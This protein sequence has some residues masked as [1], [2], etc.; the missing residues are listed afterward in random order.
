MDLTFTEEQQQFRGE[1]REWLAANKPRARFD[2]YYTPRGLEQHLTW[3]RTLFEAGYSAP[4][5]P[6]EVGGMGMDHWGQL[7]YDEECALAGLPERL[8]KMGLIHGGPTVLAHG[9]AEQQ[10]AWLPGIL[11][12]SDIWC[13]GF[14]EPDAGSD[15]AAVRTT[16]RVEGDRLIINGQ[17]TWTS[18]GAIASRMFALVRTDPSA[19]QHHGIS[20]VVF[21]LDL[22]G[23]EVRPMTQMHGHSGFAEVFF[24][25]VEVPLANV[26]GELNDGWRIA[27][28]SLRL[29]RGT[30][31][32]T[33]TRLVQSLRE[34]ADT[35]RERGADDS[36]VE[37][38]GSLRAWTFAYE[39]STYALTDLVSRGEDD[40]A[41]SSINKLAWS[42]IQTAVH[43]AHLDA[44][45]SD[46]EI[47]DEAGPNGEFVGM[48]R[49]YWHARAAEIFAGANEI[50][51]NIIAERGFGL[52]REPRG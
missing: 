7:I 22:P 30:G 37:N 21:D 25:D 51:R 19:S 26:V 3:E 47:V 28:T 41:A 13:Q 45:G 48:R 14:S 50:Q 1:L 46:G 11:D 23:V 8:N 52:P 2:P 42:E 18:F 43:E 17:K 9:T 15:L 32:G 40:G 12:S 31:R 36:L 38:L 49:D 4:G 10:A 6:V 29:E 35:V 20:F 34:L 39:Q 5:W 44:L 27:G 16:G 33:H 24:T